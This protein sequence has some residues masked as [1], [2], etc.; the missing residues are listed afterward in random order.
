MPEDMSYWSPRHRALSRNRT[1]L[2]QEK[3]ELPRPKDRW[4]IVCLMCGQEAEFR[5][6]PEEVLVHIVRQRCSRCRGNLL[7]ESVEGDNLRALVDQMLAGRKKS[8]R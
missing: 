8:L 3:V 4:E 6:T 1:L 2:R 5:G 7:A